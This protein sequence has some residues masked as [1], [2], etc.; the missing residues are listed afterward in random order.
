M[1]CL[2]TPCRPVSVG[3]AVVARLG[4]LEGEGKEGEKEGERE[5]R[6]E[7]EREGATRDALVGLVEIEGR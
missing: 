2:S 4:V 7:G 6:E 5:E 1:W 3:E